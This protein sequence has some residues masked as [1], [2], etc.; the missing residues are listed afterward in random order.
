MLQAAGSSSLTGSRR[1]RHL[2]RG[3]WSLDGR[4]HSVR[5]R[6]PSCDVEGRVSCSP[7]RLASAERSVSRTSRPLDRRGQ[8]AGY[9][10]GAE[11]SRAW[12]LLYATSHI[13]TAH[14]SRCRR[15]TAAEHSVRTSRRCTDLTPT[16]SARR[17]TS[18]MSHSN[19]HDPVAV[20]ARARDGGS[21]AR[22]CA[23]EAA[24]CMNALSQERYGLL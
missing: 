12:E 19:G 9:C 3:P 11:D 17:T 5:S 6:R 21:R 24:G 22:A 20:D 16:R 13:L 10:C 14:F 1:R 4:D 8:T 18:L 7:S 15:T 2:N 23:T